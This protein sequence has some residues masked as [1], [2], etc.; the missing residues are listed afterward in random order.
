MGYGM[1][2][3]G[4]V[5]LGLAVWGDPLDIVRQSVT[6]RGSLEAPLIRAIRDQVRGLI[7]IPTLALG[8]VAQLCGSVWASISPPVDIDVG[9]AAAAASAALALVM[10]LYRISRH[11][12][13]ASRL[14][15]ALTAE[16]E[17]A[18]FIVTRACRVFWPKACEAVE[19]GHQ[20]ERE[21][22]AAVLDALR[23][24]RLPAKR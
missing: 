18:D 17:G 5:L 13:P 3:G 2:I 8:F 21:R 22:T 9:V 1:D 23:S 12:L 11:R 19:A 14:R 6:H 20:R 16:M 7:G 4:A 10:I 15:L 24:G